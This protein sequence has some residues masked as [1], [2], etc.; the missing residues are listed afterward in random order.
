MPEPFLFRTSL[1]VRL[2]ETDVMGIVFHGNFF[3]YMEVGR[4]DYLR[5]IG[6]SDPERPMKGMDNV[7]KHAACD[8]ESPARFDDLLDIYVR[9]AEIRNTSFR[10]E[11][12]ITKG[13]EDTVVAKGESVHV[14]IDA[15]SWKPTRVPESFRAPVRAF[16]GPA[17]KE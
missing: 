12:L 3:L 10:F 15:K 16:E 11:F 7:V 17:L 4:M 14:A 5:N 8:Y 13:V 1:R 9:V 6:L 2:P